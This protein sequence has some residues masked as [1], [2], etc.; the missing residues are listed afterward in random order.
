MYR[1]VVAGTC[2]SSGN[3]KK[4]ARE[5]IYY[6]EDYGDHEITIKNYITKV[7]LKSK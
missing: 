7:R 1:Y 6:S 3:T 4:E 2:I 5:N